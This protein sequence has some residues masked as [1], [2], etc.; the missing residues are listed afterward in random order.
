MSLIASRPALALRS[1]LRKMGIT[2]KIVQWQERGLNKEMARDLE[3]FRK[4]KPPTADAEVS[5]V[6][7]ILRTDNDDEFLRVISH[8]RDRHLIG[9]LID[10]AKSNGVFWDI[11]ANFGLYSFLVAKT[12]GCQ[13]VVCFDPDPWCQDRLKENAKLNNL[14]NV[15]FVNAGV[16][17][18]PGTMHFKMADASVGGTSHLHEGP[19]DPADKHIIEV[20]IDAGDNLQTRFN[21]PAPTL[22]KIDVEGFEWEV[23]KGLD[24]TLADP[25]CKFILIEVH[26]TLLADRGLKDASRQISKYLEDRGFQTKW[27]DPSH[28]SGKKSS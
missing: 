14:S 7:A 18:H 13:S 27:L 10:A 25:A 9:A 2:H 15:H 28:I 6:H 12:P 20:P 23:I 21:I 11:G 16:A 22:I 5:G 3:E 24:K 17:D 26:F 1:I 19:V 8:K 4:T